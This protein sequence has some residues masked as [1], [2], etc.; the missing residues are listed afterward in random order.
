MS[1]LDSPTYYA[2]NVKGYIDLVLLNGQPAPYNLFLYQLVGEDLER[3]VDDMGFVH[4]KLKPGKAK[5]ITYMLR[6][7]EINVDFD[8]IELLG[9]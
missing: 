3:S 2:R 6:G 7:H 9:Y 5:R 4:Y 8:D 1:A